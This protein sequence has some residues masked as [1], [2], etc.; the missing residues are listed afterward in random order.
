MKELSICKKN[1]KCNIELTKYICCIVASNNRAS[2]NYY[3]KEFNEC[4]RKF[5]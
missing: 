2:C 5:K 4:V 1:N 3:L